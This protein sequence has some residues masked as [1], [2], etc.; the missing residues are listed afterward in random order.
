DDT[1]RDPHDEARELLV[2]ERVES[3][4][5]RDGA[6]DR[7]DERRREREQRAERA[8]VNA[9]DEDVRDADAVAHAAVASVDERGPE[10]RGGEDER[11]VLQA[12]NEIAAER[13]LVERG[14]M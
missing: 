12:V 8:A 6:V 14:E 3:P 11:G 4:V 5:A 13:R 9:G 1:C 2:F 10:Q 7:I